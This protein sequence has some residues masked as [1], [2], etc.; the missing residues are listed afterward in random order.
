[1]TERSDFEA[2]REIKARLSTAGDDAIATLSSKALVHV[3]DV[4]KLQEKTGKTVAYHN[5]AQKYEKLGASMERINESM[6]FL[7]ESQGRLK[8]DWQAFME[9]DAENAR[10]ALFELLSACEA[11]DS[12]DIAGR[13]NAESR[14]LDKIINGLK[15]IKNS[16]PKSCATLAKQAIEFEKSLRNLDNIIGAAEYPGENFDTYSKF[17]SGLEDLG[18]R[19]R[20]MDESLHFSKDEHTKRD[21][22]HFM[23][24]D[25]ERLRESIRTSHESSMKLI[26]SIT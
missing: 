21:W 25:L 19:I 12:E 14:I 20:R 15:K 1:M 4:L 22:E 11:L 24:R 16:D 23:E 8:P 17:S 18:E 13:L 7:S 10:G 3:K 26:N 2:I 5:I 6:Q 9:A